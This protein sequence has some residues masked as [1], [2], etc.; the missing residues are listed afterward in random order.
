MVTEASFESSQF[1]SRVPARV[2]PYTANDTSFLRRW[3][4]G[5]LEQS[6][7]LQEPHKQMVQSWADIGF[8]E[9][10]PLCIMQGVPWQEALMDVTKPRTRLDTA[11]S[12]FPRW[13]EGPAATRLPLVP[14][15]DSAAE[16]HTPRESAHSE[17]I[18][19]WVNPTHHSPAHSSNL[20]SWLK[21]QGGK[22]Q[23]WIQFS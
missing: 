11:S 5:G 22:Q 19:L 1:D 9:S 14:G 3:R 15:T 16:G 12:W 10:T 6:C 13:L 23:I 8:L 2:P 17:A 4:R 21:M 18:C 7:D 20:S